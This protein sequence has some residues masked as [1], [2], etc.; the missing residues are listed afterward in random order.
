MEPYVLEDRTFLHFQDPDAKPQ[1]NK[2]STFDAKDLQGGNYGK[3]SNINQEQYV[4]ETKYGR[5]QMS[6]STVAGDYRAS[7]VSD[8][9]SYANARWSDASMSNLEFGDMRNMGVAPYHDD[10]A[11]YHGQAHE[12]GT[13]SF[14]PQGPYSG[15]ADVMPNIPEGVD[16]LE[17][18]TVILRN[19][20]CKYT[21]M[22]LFEELASLNF[23]FDFLYLP[24]ARRVRRNLGYAFINFKSHELAAAFVANMQGYQFLKQPNSTKRL[25]VAYSRLQGFEE[26][27]KFYSKV[28]E[29]NDK[30]RPWVESASPKK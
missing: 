16:G 15:Q 11:M 26:N 5:N 25:E 1:F 8:R 2:A 30:C 17:H 3:G 19:I 4:Y 28:R 27:V 9:S 6:Q 23:P 13:I 20:P 29:T 14:G 12:T 7:G 10:Y 22:A 21:Q 24:L 18:T